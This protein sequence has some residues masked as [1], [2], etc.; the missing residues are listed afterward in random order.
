M[1]PFD[2]DGLIAIFSAAAWTFY[3]QAVSCLLVLRCIEPELERPFRVWLVVPIAFSAIAL[4][5][6]AAIVFEQPIEAATSLAFIL[7][8]I[9]VYYISD[10]IKRKYPSAYGKAEPDVDDDS[11]A[12]LV[13][14]NDALGHEG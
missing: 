10:W 6:V 12:P 11:S 1:L 5:L 9:P 3:L 14:P 2:L 8:A 4:L 13:L 7:S